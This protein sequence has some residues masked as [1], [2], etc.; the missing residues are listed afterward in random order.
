MLMFVWT[1]WLHDFY[2][3]R[4]KFTK[5]INFLS[6]NKKN[7][8]CLLWFS[9]P[10]KTYRLFSTN[11]THIQLYILTTESEACANRQIPLQSTWLWTTKTSDS[12]YKHFHYFTRGCRRPLASADTYGIYAVFDI[13]YMITLK[14]VSS[15]CIYVLRVLRNQINADSINHV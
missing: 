8:L 14:P 11:V 10:K 15:G 5:I 4:Y 13:F 7:P 2:D 6:P 3:Q 9:H 1:N 12:N